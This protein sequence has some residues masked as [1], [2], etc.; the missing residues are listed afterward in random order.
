MCRFYEINPK[1]NAL[2]ED[3]SWD[4]EQEEWNGCCEDPYDDEEEEKEWCD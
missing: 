4:S 1:L 3:A 2:D